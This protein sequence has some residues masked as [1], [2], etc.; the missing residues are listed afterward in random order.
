MGKYYSRYGKNLYIYVTRNDVLIDLKYFP[1][2]LNLFTNESAWRIKE[3]W[4]S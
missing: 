2:E 4:R 3:K 1:P